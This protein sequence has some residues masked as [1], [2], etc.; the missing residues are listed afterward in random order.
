MGGGGFNAGGKFRCYGE[1][2]EEFG[3][4]VQLTFKAV[5]NTA[6]LFFL[7]KGKPIIRY[8]QCWRCRN[9][10]P[11]KKPWV[12]LKNNSCIKPFC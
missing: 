9:V 11:E 6:L 2:L 8:I 1:G 3:I 7:P 4:N 5:V 10:P 12:H